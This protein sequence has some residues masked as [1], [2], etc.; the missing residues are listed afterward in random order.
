MVGRVYRVAIPKPLLLRGATL[1]DGFSRRPKANAAILIHN[2]YITAVGSPDEFGV[3]AEAETL[4]LTGKW[5]IPGLI[6]MHCHIKDVSANYFVAAGVTTVRNTAGWLRE[7]ADLRNAPADAPTPRVISAGRIID[8]PPGCWPG[9]TAPG[10]FIADDPETARAEVRREAAEGADWIKVY[11]MLKLPVMR[12]VVEEASSLGLP[13]SCDLGYQK[14]LTIRE[15]ARMGIR[16]NEHATGFAQALY[17]GWKVSWENDDWGSAWNDGDSPELDQLCEEVAESGMVLCPTMELWDQAA[18]LPDHWWPEHP[19]ARAL[20]GISE[21]MQYYASFPQELRPGAYRMGQHSQAV[22]RAYRRAGGTVV[23][24][25]DTPALS[26]NA[27]GL[28][29]HREFQLLVQN[30]WSPLEAIWAATS[31]AARVLG[32]NDLGVIRPGAVADAVILDGDPL[33]DVANTL[34]TDRVVKGGAVYTPETAMVGIPE[35]KVFMQKYE[36]L[37]AEYQASAEAAAAAGH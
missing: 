3:P 29:L 6:D 28:S 17:L 27:P 15:A 20:E 35:T 32:R 10:N 22:A 33:A 18:H 19:V 13:V 9:G 25:T 30:G 2:G 26:W 23:A 4:D 34:L 37:M 8:G 11:G 5:V 1:I 31:T 12:A 14:Y 24:G 16:T 21:T 36:R 7:L